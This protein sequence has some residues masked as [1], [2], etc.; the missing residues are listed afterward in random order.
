MRTPPAAQKRTSADDLG[1]SG[2]DPAAH[3]R[4]SADDLGVR[5]TDPAARKRTSAD[6]LGVN[7][8]DPAARK[9]T[10][11]GGDSGY[12][13]SHRLPEAGVLSAAAV[14]GPKDG[15]TYYQRGVGLLGDMYVCDG[16]SPGQ[17]CRPCPV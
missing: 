10:F 2:T 4:T 8:T 7:G 17:G 11:C 13:D 6:D 14:G 9:R 16:R 12:D 5:G 1:V 3:T 15:Y